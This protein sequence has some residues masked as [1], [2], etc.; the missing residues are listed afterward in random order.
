[1]AF[2]LLAHDGEPSRDWD[3][4]EIYMGTD[5][6]DGQTLHIARVKDRVNDPA[7]G[8][9]L[10]IAMS[11][12]IPTLELKV[13]YSQQGQFDPNSDSLVTSLSMRQPNST[14][15]AFFDVTQTPPTIQID[16]RWIQYDSE[17]VTMIFFKGTD[18]NKLTGTIISERRDANGDLIG[19]NIPLFPHN[20]AI[21]T[22]KRPD[23]FTTSYPLKRGDV[24]TGVAY[25]AVGGV[26]SE[27]P[28]VVVESATIRAPSHN[29]IF[30]ENLTMK[31]PL[32]SGPDPKL[33][34][35]SQGTP[36]N[37]SL[38]KGVL[39]YSDGS[40]TEVNVDGTKCVVH[41]LDRFDTSRVGTPSDIMISYY[42]DITEPFIN[43][44]A[45]ATKHL[46]RGYKLANIAVDTSYA[47]K[48]YPVPKFISTAIGY[49]FKWRVTNMAGDLDIDVTA[50]I[51]ASLP[52]G[53]GIKGN[54]YGVP[55]K[56]TIAL[57]MDTIAPGVYPGHIHT[58]I[59]DITLSIPGSGGW[60]PW[61]IDYIGGGVNNY[62]I[63]LKVSA[64]NVNGGKFKVDFG[65]MNVTDWLA[66]VYLES[67]PLW[68]IT[69][70]DKPITPSHFI[71]EYNG[72]TSEHPVA[73]FK[74]I[75]DKVVTATP[76][77]D[78]QTM[79]IVW[80]YRSGSGDRL[81]AM[82]PVLIRADL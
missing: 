45:G 12:N 14:A 51:I 46:T 69:F 3:I 17:P 35:N 56:V 50:D 39:W 42:P 80:I 7:K 33:L 40:K 78:N 58:Q 23:V 54:N 52:D 53:T 30:L 37:T 41:G 66:K 72:V 82:S 4:S 68:D 25:T 49:E 6:V 62:G 27:E 8:L 22:E 11:G 64:T 81:L 73:T 34:L 18:T 21:N 75:L 47:L 55:Q 65:Q 77:A 76:F 60:S 61:V 10:V 44:G 9:Y 74:N 19:V 2:Q 38:I 13:K 79:N 5:P 36:F 15:K 70:T 1:M 59:M 28:F 29:A 26:F 20:P 71:L 16:G 67:A 32:I 24:I 57:N 31:S 63:D 43:G 48:V